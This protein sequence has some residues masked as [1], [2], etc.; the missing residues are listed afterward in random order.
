[1]S[2]V[3]Q[4]VCKEMKFCNESIMVLF[5]IFAMQIEMILMQVAI[6]WKVFPFHAIFAECI[7]IISKPAAK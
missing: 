1:M 5:V 6:H 7:S 2:L 4:V 3:Y